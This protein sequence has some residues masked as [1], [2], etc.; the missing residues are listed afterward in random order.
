[1]YILLGCHSTA[2]SIQT[3]L[4]QFTQYEYICHLFSKNA[5][6]KISRCCMTPSR[7]H[8]Q[9]QRNICCNTQNTRLKQS[10]LRDDLLDRICSTGWYHTRNNNSNNDNNQLCMRLSYAL[11]SCHLFRFKFITNSHRKDT[12]TSIVRSTANTS[13]ISWWHFMMNEQTQ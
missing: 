1:M 4:C 7:L 2:I 9:S 13:S 12:S 3:I 11:L 6:R 5:L 10:G 8:R